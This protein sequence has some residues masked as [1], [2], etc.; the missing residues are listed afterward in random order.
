MINFFTISFSKTTLKVF[1]FVNVKANLFRWRITI[2]L[3]KDTLLMKRIICWF[4]QANW[5]HFSFLEIASYNS[6]QN[7]W[8]SYFVFNSTNFG[9]NFR[10]FFF[11]FK[12]FWI[13]SSI[14]DSSTSRLILIIRTISALLKSKFYNLV[15]RTIETKKL[16]I[17]IMCTKSFDMLFCW[18]RSNTI[19][20]VLKKSHFLM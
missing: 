5:R 3:S 11:L 12:I 6:S 19:V 8:I 15:N 10:I 18:I 17:Q 14:F 20:C 4:F 16:F 2:F 7:I 13:F 9:S 1:A